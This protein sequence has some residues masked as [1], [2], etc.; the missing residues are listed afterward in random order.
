VRLEWE[1]RETVVGITEG[2]L[3]RRLARK[4]GGDSRFVI[5]EREDGSYVQMLGGGVAC[6]LEWRDRQGHRHYR[7][8][9]DPPRVPWREPALLDRMRLS[10]SE[11]LFIEDVVDAFCA[12]LKG[13]PFPERIRWRDVTDE[14]QA[15]GIAKP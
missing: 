14:L 13:C 2:Q 4:R 15:V 9:L 3:R 6:C 12:F 5:L 10:P 7:A 8:F 11:F 1:D